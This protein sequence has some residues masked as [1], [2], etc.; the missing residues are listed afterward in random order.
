MVY[1]APVMT[2]VI[3]ITLPSIL[4]LYWAATTIFSIF[5]QWL[6]K[7]TIKVEDTPKID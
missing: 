3:L 2:L 4:A 7:K 5:Q 6:I 1:I